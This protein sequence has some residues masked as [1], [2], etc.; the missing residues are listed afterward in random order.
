MLKKLTKPLYLAMKLSSVL[1]IILTA[2]ATLSAASGKSQSL[3]NVKLSVSFANE[4]LYSAVKKLEKRSGVHFSYEAGKLKEYRVDRLEYADETIGNILKE[5]LQKT[6]LTATEMNNS[7]VIYRNA[8][9]PASA[10]QDS[11][12][13]FHRQDSLIVTGLVTDEQGPLP[14]VSILVKGTQHGTST[15]PDGRYSLENVPG[16]G[17]LVFSFLGYTAVEEPVNGRS[18][19]NVTLN[20][21][22]ALLEEIV[23]TALGI[24]REE[25]SLGYAVQKISGEAIRSVKSV[26]I[27]TALTGKIAGLRVN[28]S[29]EFYAQPSISLRGASPLLVIDGVPYG[30]M[31]LRDISADNIENISVLKGATASALYG[32][33]GGNGAIIITTKKGADK[34][35]LAVTVNSNTMFAAGFLTLPEVQHSYSAGLGGNYDPTD[36][37]WGAKLDIGTMAMQWDPEL[38]EMRNMELTSRGKDNF[39]NFL[40]T[41]FVTNTSVSVSQSGERGSFRASAS[42][43]YHKGQYPNA[44]VNMT[45]FSL[46]GEMKVADKF[47]MTGTMGYSRRATPQINGAG[48]GDQGYMYNILMWTGPEYNLEKYRDYWITPDVQQNWLYK[49]WYD[50]PYLMAYE[51][52]HGIHENTFNMSLS[53]SYKLFK[54][55]NLMVRSGLDYYS[56]EDTQRNPPNINGTRGGWDAKG[57]YS[58]DNSTGFSTNNDLIFTINKEYSSFGVNLLAGGT[59]YFYKDKNLFASTR[60]GLSIPGFYS[61]ESSVERPNTSSS[62]FR[63]QVNSLFG[64]LSLSWKSALFLDVT[65]RNDWSSTLPEATRSYF[66]PSVATSIVVSELA[67]LPSWLQFWKLRGSWAVSKN[68]LGVYDLNRSF[69]TS[70]GVWN[71]LNAASYPDNIGS[72]IISPETSRTWEVGTEAYFLRGRLH[73]DVAYFNKYRYNLQTNADISEASG[74][75]STLINTDQSFVRKGM[76]ITLGGT[77]VKS[78]NFQW[79]ATVNWSF[80]H[81]YYKELDSIYSP[82][83]MWVKEGARED[84]YLYYDW[85]RDANGNVVYQNG[86]PVES[87]YQSRL[88]FED[89]NWIFGFSNSFAYKNLELTLSFD[90]RVGGIMYNYI[91]DKMWDTGSHPDSDN[92]WRYDEV[93]HGKTNYIG[94]G[95]KVISG[96]VEYDKY[97]RIT[98]DTRAFEKNDVPVSYESFARE[99]RGGIPDGAMDPTFIKL[100]EVS[101]KYRFPSS[102]TEKIGASAASVAITGQNMFLWLK[103][104]RYSDPDRGTEDL[105]SPAVRYI[106]MNLNL[107]F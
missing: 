47:N 94:D 89:P 11:P 43:I 26:D 33:R 35:G 24:E 96:A 103:E 102:L 4:S 72:G 62:E 75:E 39:S 25:K 15:G 53:A 22:R 56:D 91:N 67:Q 30:N 16:N 100:R 65:G 77:P 88:G 78:G 38:K 70:L 87:D 54:D 36:Y 84:N 107:T 63:K 79:N 14:G 57:I 37:V 45:N 68:D 101:L 50:N 73:M 23:V 32:A 51:K 19:I 46:A 92:Q 99:Y 61:L 106:G 12:A 27:G 71:G 86:L 58:I 97:G 69:S 48:Y 60:N 55:A 42:D 13:G 6:P 95:V 85:V 2:S 104:F 82:D 41:G 90:G 10:V 34:D 44:K 98:S 74:F 29:T 76:E 5:L 93:V 80:T 40:E 7:L 52:L 18:D 3:K 59:I 105:N 17:I 31:S 28:N 83:N 21:E 81:L 20:V 1:L 49:A 8:T 64:K 9:S 66:Y